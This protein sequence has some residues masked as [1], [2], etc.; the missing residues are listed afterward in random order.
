MKKTTTNILII[1]SSDILYEG[2]SHAL[3][4]ADSSFHCARLNILEDMDKSIHHQ[5]PDIVFLSPSQVLKREDEIRHLRACHENIILVGVMIN[6]INQEALT[7]Y[8]LTFSLYDTIGTIVKN[9]H[10]QME[11]HNEK[12]TK[13]KTDSTLTKREIE[14]LQELIQGL[15]S[16]EIA[17]KLNI[18]IHTVITH[19]KNIILKTGIHSQS[20]LALYAI[21]KHY[22]SLKDFNL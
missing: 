5:H 9:L 21:S 11:L 8:D 7:L 16:K 20:G 19:R 17:A 3:T 12:N 18:S 14:I 6:M 13:T 15:T 10:K 4:R 22:A 2:L 1:E